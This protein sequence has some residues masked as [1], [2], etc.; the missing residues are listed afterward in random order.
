V[1]G[2]RLAAG[3]H[4]IAVER[5]DEKLLQVGKRRFARVRFR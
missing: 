4:E 5:G 3:D 2:E 1:D